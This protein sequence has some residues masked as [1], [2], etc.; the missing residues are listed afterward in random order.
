MTLVHVQSLPLLFRL[1]LLEMCRDVTNL[2][3]YSDNRLEEGMFF[4]SYYNASWKQNKHDQINMRSK[5]VTF[6]SFLFR[7][8]PH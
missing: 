3:L 2:Y 5:E 6:K 7:A 4:P 8:N 1:Y